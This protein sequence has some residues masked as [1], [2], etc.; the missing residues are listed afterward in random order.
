MKKQSILAIFCVLISAAPFILHAD[1]PPDPNA[2]QRMSEVIDMWV[3]RG[4]NS[5]YA[6]SSESAEIDEFGGGFVGSDVSQL[7][8]DPDLYTFYNYVNE[9]NQMVIALINADGNVYGVAVFP[10]EG[11][12]TFVLSAEDNVPFEEWLQGAN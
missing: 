3:Q 7:L 5:P 1:L 11:S 2:P 4:L 12:D 10:N 8:S 9:N 6:L